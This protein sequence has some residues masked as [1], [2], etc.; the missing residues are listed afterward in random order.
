MNRDIDLDI[1][2][3]VPPFSVH[4]YYLTLSNQQRDLILIDISTQPENQHDYQF[5]NTL[6]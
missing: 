5:Y 6:N 1:E 2:Y 4:G 3:V